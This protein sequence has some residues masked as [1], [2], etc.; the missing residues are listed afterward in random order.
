[1]SQNNIAAIIFEQ[2]IR[3]GMDIV[4]KGYDVTSEKYFLQLSY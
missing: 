1:V 2:R 4:A 3:T